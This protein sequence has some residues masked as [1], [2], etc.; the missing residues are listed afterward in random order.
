MGATTMSAI[1]PVVTTRKI[2][3]DDEY[4]WAVLLNGNI[5]FSGLNKASLP[6]YKKLALKTYLKNKTK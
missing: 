2:G 4:S 1:K 5:C 3:G 6:Y